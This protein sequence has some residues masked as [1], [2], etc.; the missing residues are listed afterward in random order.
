MEFE[1]WLYEIWMHPRGYSFYHYL[2]VFIV[3]NSRLHLV[4]WITTLEMYFY[5]QL[6][7]IAFSEICPDISD[8]PEEFVVNKGC[9]RECKKQSY[10]QV[11]CEAVSLPLNDT[12]K[13]I[14][15]RD[16]IHGICTNPDQIYGF[17]KC[18]GQCDTTAYFD[19]SKWK[20]IMYT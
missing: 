1:W 4:K 9:C 11:N 2:R 6:R 18:S 12:I 13:I 3:S 17:T 20:L 19:E 14:Y 15:K 16:L 5:F 7:V 10:S 8:C